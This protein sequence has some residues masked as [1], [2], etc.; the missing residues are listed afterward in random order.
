MPQTTLK[1]NETTQSFNKKASP[2]QNVHWHDFI[3]LDIKDKTLHTQTERFLDALEKSNRMYTCINSD[4]SKSPFT[5]Q[6]LL[7]AVADWHKTY[8][9]TEHA[10]FFEHQLKT[11]KNAVLKELGG[12]QRDFN[13]L[14]VESSPF[15]HGFVSLLDSA[16]TQTPQLAPPPTATGAPSL[17]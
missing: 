15:P 1:A 6:D 12:A 7:K 5:G 3:M 17:R 11:M 16:P 10:Q 9:S 4:G 2:D 14:T 13:N 8:Q